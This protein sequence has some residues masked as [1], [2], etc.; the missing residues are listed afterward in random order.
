MSIPLLAQR[1]ELGV[2]GG[3]TYYVGDINPGMPFS[4]TSPAYGILY[5]YNL[6]QRL[7]IRGTF[8]HGNLKSSD[9]TAGNTPNRLWSFDASVNEVSAQ[10]ELNFLPYITGG[11]N[12]T[13]APYLFG[14]AALLFES[15]VSNADPPS[16]LIIPSMP[17]G[18]GVK[19]SLS[20]RLCFGG[21]W[22][23]RK[24]LTDKIDNMPGVDDK[25]RQLGDMSNND[26]YS[27]AGITLTYALRLKDPKKCN[28]FQ[29]KFG[30]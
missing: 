23:Y 9:L 10:L 26:W 29:N 15:V 21:E 13:F 25:G 18:M 27:F 1:G 17:F 2:I 3:G 30:Y 7:T 22:G 20:K 5:R 19:I 11:I 14:G 28:D 16:N 24:T 4:M 6:N 12:S 8:W